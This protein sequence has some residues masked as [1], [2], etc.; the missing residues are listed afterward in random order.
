MFEF[1]AGLRCCEVPVGLGVIGISLVFPGIDLVDEGL[2]VG[3]AAIEAFRAP[4][5]VSGSRGRNGR[6]SSWQPENCTGFYFSEGSG[7]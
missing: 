4:P 2:L 7:G 3:D 6:A 5:P 1:D